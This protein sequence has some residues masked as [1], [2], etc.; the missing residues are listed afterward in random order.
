MQGAVT[1]KLD[2]ILNNLGVNINSYHGSDIN[3]YSPIDGSFMSGLAA[4]T[5]ESVNKK[6]ELS[7]AA[8]KKWKNLPAPKR[9][10]LIK[11]FGNEVRK[12]KELLGRLITLECG[13]ALE[14][15]MGEVQEIIDIC[16]YAVGLSRQIGGLTLP[17]E[18]EDHVMQ[19]DWLPLGP[20]GVI[21][22]FNFPAAVWG[23]N[24]AIAIICG[25]TVLWKPSEKTPLTALAC[26]AIFNNAAKQFEAE[27][28]EGLSQII[29]GFKNVGELLV[30]DN[31]IPLISATGSCAMGSKVGSLV[32]KRFGKLLLELGGN[33]AVIVSAN[34][35]LEIALSSVLFGAVGTAGQR[36]T[37][38]RRAFVHNDVF[39]EFYN[40]LCAAYNNL[41]CKIGDPTNT[42]NLIGPLIDKAAFDNMQNTLHEVRKYNKA[43]IIGGERVLDKKY[44]EAYYVRPALVKLDKQISIVKQETFAPILYIMP[45][46]DLLEAIEMQNDV[47]Q[48]LSSALFTNDIKEAQI[49]RKYSDC[50]IANVNIGTSGAEIGGAFGGEKET[51]GGR[52]AGSDSWKAYMRRQ[53][54][55]TYYGDRVPKLAQG[56]KFDLN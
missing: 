4:D 8:F 50:G 55:T 7:L 49:F 48:G 14:E 31:R 20:V 26:Q 19:E 52:E 15:G 45:Y 3:V 44:E 16:D 29:L 46:S 41:E 38:T 28:P 17:S 9:G 43:T 36:C 23:W 39:A 24:M 30:S 10:Q 40:R 53:T 51:G 18:R 6:I 33:N 42:Q 47:S 12:N 35:D 11:I 22:A 5:K 13:K 34:C 1:M 25:D 54:S 2:K 21:S 27:V 56:I 32:I 37:T